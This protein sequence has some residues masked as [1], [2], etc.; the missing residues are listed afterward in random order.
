MTRKKKIYIAARLRQKGLKEWVKN[1]NEE[2]S[3]FSAAFNF[4]NLVLIDQKCVFSWGNY[5][6]IQKQRHIRIL[7]HIWLVVKKRKK[8][9]MGKI[10]QED[11]GKN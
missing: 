4:L 7:M 5:D 3:D 10:R 1:T 8:I 9:R 11:N 2:N 6:I